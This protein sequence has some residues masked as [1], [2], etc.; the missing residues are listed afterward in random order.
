[1]FMPA[2]VIGLSVFDPCS[3]S[4]LMKCLRV[5]L[6][7]SLVIHAYSLSLLGDPCSIVVEKSSE[8]GVGSSGDMSGALLDREGGGGGGKLVL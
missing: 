4:L 8:C 6:S 5:A 1:M 3:I 7:S 2:F